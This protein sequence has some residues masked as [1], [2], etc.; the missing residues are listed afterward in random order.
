MDSNEKL[1]IVATNTVRLH[2]QL[3]ELV[4]AIDLVKVLCS[5]S[6]NLLVSN[7]YSEASLRAKDG[8]GLLSLLRATS[9]ELLEAVVSEVKH[10]LKEQKF[11]KNCT[12][13]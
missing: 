11:E 8:D 6:I 9:L 7:G 4:N 13:P 2:Q 1:Y 10:E 12:S 5:D 3:K